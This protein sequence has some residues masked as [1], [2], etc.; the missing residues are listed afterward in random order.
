MERYL[1]ELYPIL[2]KDPLATE[3]RKMQ[4]L[5]SSSI[6]KE[7]K[8]EFLMSYGLEQA[9]LDRLTK[10]TFQLLGMETIFTAGEKEIRSWPIKKNTPAVNAAGCIHS[11]I[12][13]GFIKAEVYSLENLLEYKSDEALIPLMTEFTHDFI[14]RIGADLEGNFIPIVFHTFA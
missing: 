3:I 10:E 12:E 6:R 14:L 8:S 11:D 9:G 4:E 5:K 1:P 13:R 2:H 7:E